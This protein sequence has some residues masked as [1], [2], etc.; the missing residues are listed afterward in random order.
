VLGRRFSRRRRAQLGSGDD[1]SLPPPRNDARAS[2]RQDDITRAPPTIPA[3][4]GRSM[5]MQLSGERNYVNV[6]LG[7]DASAVVGGFLLDFGA[8]GSTVDFGGFSP[9][10][11]TPASC[12]G[13]AGAPGA[14]CAFAGFD[15]FRDW[16]SVNLVTADYSF[17][18][19]PPRQ[20]G[21]IGTAFLSVYPFTLD[22]VGQKL[23][24]SE[25]RAFCSDAQ[26]LAAGFAPLPSG[27]FYTHT[28]SSLRPLS[29]VIAGD[30]DATAGF[31]VPNVP[32][33][34]VS[35]S[36]VSALAKLDTGYD[37]RIIRHPINVNQPLLD[38]ILAKDSAMIVRDP[39]KDLYLTTCVPGF[40]QKAE[41]YRFIAPRNVEFLAEGG[42]V[43]RSDSTPI[44]FLKHEEG[45]SASCG[46]I[47]TWTVPA[48]QLGVVVPRRRPSRDLRSVRVARLDPEELSVGREARKRT[49]R[50]P[51]TPRDG[52]G[53]R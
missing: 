45:S 30:P 15:F 1:A 32:T 50:T 13:D 28:F 3:C 39:T 21:I 4:V 44:S 11:P 23:W 8:N 25:P 5:P 17:L 37:D 47:E 7:Y 14:P 27:G 43:A 42:S 24:R 2:E 18:V 9:I 46:G 48:A 40:S 31:T 20:A 33:V 38:A 34:P 36:G 53:A 51:K 41:A 52:V 22:Y 29:D 10:G 35:I 49:A 16:G 26:L 6:R 12:S 19:N